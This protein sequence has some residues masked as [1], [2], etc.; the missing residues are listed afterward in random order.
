M[1]EIYD[2]AGTDL[3]EARKPGITSHSVLVE[4]YFPYAELEPL[5]E[6]EDLLYENFRDLQTA[7]YDGHELCLNTNEATLFFY[8][9]N[10]ET[11][12]KAVKPQLDATLFLKGAM[13]RLIFGP[14]PETASEIEVIIGVTD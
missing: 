8:G 1:I 7:N 12:F 9:D 14:D 2:A 13:A 3:Q 4:F 10:A 5:F 6:L 11:L